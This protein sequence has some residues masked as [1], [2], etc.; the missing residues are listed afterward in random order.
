[1]ND[2]VFFDY[3]LSYLDGYEISDTS[4]YAKIGE[5]L[6]IQG[7][8]EGLS[9]MKDGGTAKLLIPSNI[10]YGNSGYYFPAWT[11]VIFDIHITGLVPSAEK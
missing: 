3:T 7:V 9:Y 11:P 8:E 6:V 5:G 1:M 4:Y 10:G 2:S